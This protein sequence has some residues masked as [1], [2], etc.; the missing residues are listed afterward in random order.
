MLRR[1]LVIRRQG[2]RVGVDATSRGTCCRRRAPSTGRDNM[3]FPYAAVTFTGQQHQRQ[4]AHAGQGHS[5]AGR[6]RQQAWRW[7]RARAVSRVQ[8][9][10]HPSTLAGGQLPHGHHLQPVARL[11]CEAMGINRLG[12]TLQSQRIACAKWLPARGGSLGL[13]CRSPCRLTQARWTTAA[14]HCT[15]RTTRRM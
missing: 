2:A 10:P 4:P 1:R 7:R 13:S 3:K 11:R 12:W 8:P 14:R 9:D 6:G 15:S 5:R